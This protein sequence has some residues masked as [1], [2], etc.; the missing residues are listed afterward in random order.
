MKR[1]LRVLFAA[2]AAVMAMAG[3]GSALAQEADGILKMYNP[4]SPASMSIRYRRPPFAVTLQPGYT[5]TEVGQPGGAAPHFGANNNIT[6]QITSLYTGGRITDNLGAF[7]QGTYDSVSRRFGWDQVDI[8][9]A[10]K[11]NVAGHNLLWGVTLNIR[12]RA[13]APAAAIRPCPPLCAG[14]SP[15]MSATLRARWSRVSA[16]M[17]SQILDDHQ[18]AFLQFEGLGYLTKNPLVVRIL[19]EPLHGLAVGCPV[20][21]SDHAKGLPRISTRG[22]QT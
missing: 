1:D 18:G 5:H 2:G 22:A 8:R 3:A 20:G 15:G 7:I 11:V 10:D 16:S 6:V 21:V 17:R 9:Y 19:R 12:C 14:A 13:K 4:D